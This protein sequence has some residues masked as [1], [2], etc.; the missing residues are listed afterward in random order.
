MEEPAE[1]RKQG[2]VSGI[3]PISLQVIQRQLLDLASFQQRLMEQYAFLGRSI[4]QTLVQDL[5]RMLA[6]F[7]SLKFSIVFDVSSQIYDLVKSVANWQDG[8]TLQIQEI[9]RNLDTFNRSLAANLAAIRISFDG[10]T[11]SGIFKEIFD[12]IEENADIREAFKAA[13][14]PISPSMP[15]DLRKRVVG[16]YKGGRKRY[17]TVTIMGYYH[18]RGFKNLRNVVDS[19]DENPLFSP[20]MHILRDALEAHC[21]GKYT[22][23]VPALLPQIEGVLNDYVCS[24]HLPARIGKINQVL[25][26]VFAEKDNYTLFTWS[27]ADTLHYQLQ[28]SSYAFADFEQELKRAVKSR[29]ATRHTILHGVNPGYNRPMNSL[30]AFLLLDAINYLQNLENDLLV[31]DCN[32]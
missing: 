7:N 29:K 28:N 4:S 17:I 13:G 18:R 5:T 31:D 6:N 11:S 14:W 10:L 2:N 24:N 22:L 3:D 20:R 16:H 26:A 8:F 32:E 21:A 15:L 19:W 9:T 27:I 23:S 12:A 30:K 1:N 25:E